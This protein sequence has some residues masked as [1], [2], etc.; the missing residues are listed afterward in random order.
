METVLW[1]ILACFSAVV[2]MALGG[3]IAVNL[4]LRGFF[5][6]FEDGRWW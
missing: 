1:V 5:E 6:M 2:L 3:F 4:L